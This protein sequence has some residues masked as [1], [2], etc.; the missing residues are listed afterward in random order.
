M[1][2]TKEQLMRLIELW[3][4]LSFRR[5]RQFILLLILVVVA[6]LAEII[7][8]GLVLPFLGV[9]ASPEV[10]YH[11]PI[12]QDFIYLINSIFGYKVFNE[13]NQLILPVTLVFIFI[14]IASGMIRM[15]LVYVTTRLSFATGSDISIDM[16]RRTLYQDYTVHNS[17]NSS[18]V[19]NGIIT[20]SNTVINGVISPTLNFISSVTIT[21]A[22]IFTLVLINP[23]IA[24]S[25]F[26]GFGLLYLVVIYYTKKELSNNSDIVAN[27]ST[28]MIRSLQEGL[29]GI[30]DVIIYDSQEYYCQM[31]RKSDL[32]LRRAS[33][34]NVFIGQ[35]PRY[36][37][38]TI[39]MVVIS[40]IA[41]T[42]S[43]KNDGMEAAIPV[44]GAIA[45]GAQRLLPALQQL[46]NSYSQLKGSHTSFVDVLE[47]LRQPLPCF[48]EGGSP[49]SIPFC[50][51]IELKNVYF[52]YSV[53]RHNSARILSDINLNISKG[54]CIGFVGE[55]GSGKS[56]L[57][58]ILM[59]LIH[60][61][62]GEFFVDGKLMSAK[63]SRAWQSNIAHVS[64]DIH[65][66]DSTIEQ[67]IAFGINKEK[68]DFQL[69]KRVAHQAQIDDTI[70]GFE[71]K[72]KTLVGERGVRLSGGQKQRIGIARALYKQADVL[73]LDEAT[74][75]LDVNTEEAVMKSIK[76]LNKN[77][78]IFMI[79]HRL[80]TLKSCNKII[81]I[82]KGVIEYEGNY[83][84]MVKKYFNQN[85]GGSLNEKN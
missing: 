69:I 58:D 66:S 18:E 50:K 37:M 29:G 34:S 41:Y 82:E 6:S 9:I 10:V 68:I 27:H 44:L 23:N 53:S 28:K 73:V 62:K 70:E 26:F 46:Y 48:A 67:N 56:T 11:H 30:R 55:T 31:Y 19:I 16:Y 32:M 81:K 59:M 71:D 4:C 77:I 49:I 22:I 42:M 65:L 47:L 84:N 76:K 8:I 39:G 1:S 51:K 25:A 79:A 54:D 13:P 12:M 43:L 36:A 61:T 80:S 24:I 57:L 72:Y 75:A 52:N 83:Q 2:N 17:R 33:G 21:I 64:Q 60:Q 7:S 63:D 20:K 85:K 3:R 38:E 35:A 74:S 5:H 45:V 14:S 78:T 40:L 15:L